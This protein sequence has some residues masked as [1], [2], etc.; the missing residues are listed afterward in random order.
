MVTKSQESLEGVRK[1]KETNKLMALK[2]WVKAIKG[3]KVYGSIDSS[4]LYLVP[5]MVIPKKFKVPEFK[6]CNGA[7]NRRIHIIGY[8]KKMTEVAHDDK[9]LIYYFL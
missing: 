1:K 5:N 9:L 8:Y 7:I 6:K 4:K 2:E 3:S